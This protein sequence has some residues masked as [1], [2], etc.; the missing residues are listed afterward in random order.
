MF[1]RVVSRVKAY[2]GRCWTCGEMG[3]LNYK[4]ECKNCAR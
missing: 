4:K 1:K 3:D 2:R